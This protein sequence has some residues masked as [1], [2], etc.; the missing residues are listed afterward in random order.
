[1]ALKTKS[2]NEL[3][4]PAPTS[5]N[6]GISFLAVGAV[7]VMLLWGNLA[8]QGLRYAR[9]Q[10]DFASLATRGRSL[11]ILIEDKRFK[12]ILEQH[13]DVFK[14][15]QPVIA[16]VEKGE[17]SMALKLLSR[18]DAPKHP[19][20]ETL[21]VR[22]TDLEE[23]DSK[24]H[25]LS[26][27]DSDSAEAEKRLR[28]DYTEI[29]T[30]L[31]EALTGET[32]SPDSVRLSRGFYADGM[33]KGLPLLEQV[34]D[35]IDNAET[36]SV[37]ARAFRKASPAEKKQIQA[38]MNQMLPRAEQ[39][40]G[41]IENFTSKSKNDSSELESLSEGREAVVRETH[42]LLARVLLEFTRIVVSPNLAKRYQ[43]FET[44]GNVI[45]WT[46]PELKLSHA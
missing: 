20:I 45:G 18:N 13:R 43:E 44:L 2:Y 26:A 1:M 14:S 46:V 3:G 39:L 25:K 40:K 5:M 4:D 8:A 21:K 24:F 10:R 31:S 23:S 28:N 15:L 22:L 9:L 17:L 6:W 34:P 7:V 27:V 41:H 11:A 37:W 35:N 33:L 19:L 12:P 38:M 42:I 36:L 30:K 16:S 32:V 29:V